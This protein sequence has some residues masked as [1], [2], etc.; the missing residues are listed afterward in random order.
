MARTLAI[1]GGTGKLGLGLALHW[2]SVGEIVRIGSRDP[3]RA[4]EAVD[5]VRARLKDQAHLAAANYSDAADGADVVVLAVPFTAQIRTVKAV[6]D[7]LKPSAILVDTTVPLAAGIGGGLTRTL[8]PWPG[9]AAQQ[10]A[11]LVPRGVRVVAALHTIAAERL[12]EWPEELDSDVLVAGDDEHAKSIVV[13]LIEKIP[14]LRGVDAGPLE[15]ARFTEQLTALLISINRIHR[16]HGV[17]VRIT[18]LEAGR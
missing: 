18:G 16:A 8:A 3:D 1:I 5:R 9:S 10:A 2:A 17:G 4:G 13:E 12:N 7:V 11:E 14:R 6:R 15:V